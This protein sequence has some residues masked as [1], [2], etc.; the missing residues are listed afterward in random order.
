MKLKIIMFII[1][2]M[3]SV[4][5]ASASDE[6]LNDLIAKYKFE[7]NLSDSINAYDLSKDTPIETA[8]GVVGYA[9]DLQ[10]STCTHDGYC[11]AGYCYTGSDCSM[12]CDTGDMC[13]D[14]YDCWTDD[15]GGMCAPGDF[16][17]CANPPWILPDYI[18]CSLSCYVSANTSCIPSNYST[19]YG[20]YDAFK[21]IDDFT[22]SM[23]IY[24][25]DLTTNN[26]I[27][28]F[29]NSAY[30][31]GSPLT[32]FGFNIRL[33]GYGGDGFEVIIMDGAA[34]IFGVGGGDGILEN[35]WSKITVTY[36]NITDRVIGYINETVA[37]N[38]SCI[39]TPNYSVYNGVFLGKQPTGTSTD[40]K[41][42]IDELAIINRTWSPEEVEWVFNSEAGGT[43]FEF[44]AS[45]PGYCVVNWSCTG[46]AACNIDN[47]QI[48]NNVTDLNN[49]SIGYTGN[50]S[51]FT[52]LACDYCT[53]DWSCSD[54][55]AC[56][57][58]NLNDCL[59]ATDANTCNESF[60]SSLSVYSTECFYC[61]G[62]VLINESF[63]NTDFSASGWINESSSGGNPIVNGGYLYNE[64]NTGIARIYKNLTLWDVFNYT[65]IHM[66]L[67][68]SDNSTIF[69]SEL[70]LGYP[71]SNMQFIVSSNNGHNFTF[72][73]LSNTCTSGNLTEATEYYLSDFDNL[74]HNID[75]HF[76]DG[77]MFL[78]WDNEYKYSFTYSA[79]NVADK[80]QI[81][82][83]NIGQKT[84]EIFMCGNNLPVC[85]PDYACDTYNTCNISDLTTCN[86]TIDNNAC[87]I[88]YTGNY[89]EFGVFTCNYCTA[90]IS[91]G[92]LICTNNT[93]YQIYLNTNYATCCNITNL[94]T[95]CI[96]SGFDYRINNGTYVYSESCITPPTASFNYA[97]AIIVFIASLALVCGFI[98]DVPLFIFFS[99]ISWFILSAFPFIETPILRIL[100]GVFGAITM[101]IF[102]L[103]FRK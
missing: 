95:D 12:D 18:D 102:G 77:V 28:I 7:N 64:F 11:P 98:F 17:G 86:S 90:S 27:G 57:L 19:V 96:I 78:Y 23:W 41:G 75:Y 92:N 44:N 42:L 37:F 88:P 97:I 51:E 9:I 15:Y 56:G 100:I 46:Y 8:Y 26:A 25:T 48:C 91:S 79:C 55:S 33:E 4:L 59:N 32:Y 50:Y 65:D 103:S 74:E 76:Y 94:N 81:S 70:R 30:L 101:L 35:R 29:D 99:G 54:Y 24:P 43:A 67:K 2:M 58:N 85:M 49:C 52:P 82:T 31:G 72:F 6:L 36:S 47:E 53:P 87:G 80:L 63:T 93:G 10:D 84:S 38:S 69:L 34:D 20:N 13:S 16:I 66:K 3:S 60:N 68:R 62:T 22:V 40:Y 1:L 45:I 21:L 73:G 71:L 61:L 39:R 14:P 83:R 5:F 89:S